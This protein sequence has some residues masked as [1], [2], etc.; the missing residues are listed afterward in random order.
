MKA[1]EKRERLLQTIKKQN[2]VAKTVILSFE[3]VDVQSILNKVEPQ[4]QQSL[5]EKEKQ[6]IQ[7]YKEE[8]QDH[9]EDYT[10]SAENKKKKKADKTTELYALSLCLLMNVV[11][12]RMK[13]ILMQI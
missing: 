5:T 3:G 9:Q 6:I 13:S 4:S 1:E 2:E 12:Q 10:I 11:R 8:V 7:K